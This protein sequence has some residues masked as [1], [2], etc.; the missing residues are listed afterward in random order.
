MFKKYAVNFLDA[1]EYLVAQDENGSI[2]VYRVASEQEDALSDLYDTTTSFSEYTVSADGQTVT[3]KFADCDQT[4]T[5]HLD[6]QDGKTKEKLREVAELAG[7]QFVADPRWT[8]RQFGA[9]LIDFMANFDDFMSKQDDERWEWWQKLEQCMQY[10]LLWHAGEEHNV[11]WDEFDQ[12]FIGDDD[13][14]FINNKDEIMLMLD[15][16][17]FDSLQEFRFQ[18]DV[19]WWGVGK[20]AVLPNLRVIHL[21]DQGLNGY[22]NGLEQLT[23]VEKMNFAYNDIYDEYLAEFEKLSALPNLKELDLSNG[24]FDTDG[25]ALAKLRAALPNCNIIV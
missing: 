16:V 19:D 21:E 1:Q 14:D 12:C 23:Q 10:N 18:R 24:S 3:A 2:R 5:Y 11:E 8:T 13:E 9:K 25:E 20:L 17:I 7:H 4:F 6:A 22:I 15:D